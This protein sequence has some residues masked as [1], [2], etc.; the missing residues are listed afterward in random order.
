[1]T[2]AEP[3]TASPLV[4]LAA[5]IL[6]AT[7][8]EPRVLTVPWPASPRAGRGPAAGPLE[9][10]HPTL[11]RGLR[12]W[13]ERQTGQ[14]LG[15]VEQLYTFGDR[16][17]PAG[18]R[19]WRA[20]TPSRS[21]ISPW[22]ARRGPP[23][24]RLAL[25]VPLLPLRGSA[26]R[27]PPAL[28]ALQARLDAWPPPRRPGRGAPPPRPDR[29][30]LRQRRERLERGTGAGTLRASVRG[31]PGAGGGRCRH[32]RRPGHGPRS[33]PHARHGARAPAR[34]DQVPAGGVRGD[35]AGFTLGQLQLVVEAL[36]GIL[37]HKQNFRRLVAQQG[38]VEE[39]DAITAETGAAP[40]G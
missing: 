21:P 36:S 26:G 33:P 7:P 5:V 11:E 30:D 14:T 28:D 40:P 34:Q 25:L 32:P 1:M 31:R 4:G 17:P 20:G 10:A 16:K 3:A 2:E 15:Y 38:L 12:A 27:A 13:V 8:D 23:P 37:L 18:D 29:P 19:R 6:A 24:I 35:A 39:T 9:P 22:C